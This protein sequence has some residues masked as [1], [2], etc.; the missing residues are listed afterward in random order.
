MYYTPHVDRSNK[1]LIGL[2]AVEDTFGWTALAIG[3]NGGMKGASQIVVR[4]ME[5][6]SSG[7]YDDTWVVED[8]NSQDY[9][10]PSLDES[11]DLELIFAEQTANGETAWGVLLPINSCDEFDYSVHNISM[12]MHWAVGEDHSFSFHG[13]RRGQFQANL[14]LP[15]P[16]TKDQGLSDSY[17]M[18]LLM[19]IVSVVSGE[20]EIP[21]DPYICSYFELERLPLEGSKGSQRFVSAN[22]KSHSVRVETVCSQQSKQ[23]VHH[24]I[25]YACDADLT[26]KSDDDIFHRKLNPSCQ[27]MPPHCAE[28]KAVWSLGVGEDL[29]MP[30][31]VGLPFGEGKRWLVMQVH[32]YNPGLDVGIYDSSGMRLHIAPKPRSYDAGQISLLGGFDSA[33]HPNGIPAGE[34]DFEL[35]TFVVPSVCT[36][37]MWKDPINIMWVVHHMHQYGTKMEIE[38][39]REGRS[40]GVL[41]DEK[42]FD[43]TH[44]SFT[45]SLVSQLLPGDAIFLRCRY[46]TSG[47][48][49]NVH[50]GDG[51][52][53]E[54]CIAGINYWP[55]QRV[56]TQSVAQVDPTS[57]IKQCQNAGSGVFSK[58][59]LC[60][61]SFFE[62]AHDFLTL[63]WDY[64]EPFDAL[65]FCNSGIFEDDVLPRNLPISLCPDC[66]VNK[67][68]TA[69]EVI[70]HA[71][72]KVCVD[73][74]SMAN[75]SVYPDLS[76]SEGLSHGITRCFSGD[77]QSDVRFFS[78]PELEA[79]VP[80]CEPFP[81]A[82]ASGD[83]VART[84]DASVWKVASLSMVGII[85]TAVVLFAF[86]RTTFYS[87]SETHCLGK[88]SHMWTR[89]IRSFEVNLVAF[90]RQIARHAALYPRTYVVAIS[91]LSLLLLFLGFATNF[92]VEADTLSWWTPAGT[93]SEEHLNYVTGT[94]QGLP[95]AF[96]IMVHKQGDNAV[97]KE[98]VA[99][100]FEALDAIRATQGFDAVCGKSDH[101][102]S[103]SG[104]GTCKI[105]G[106]TAFWNHS[107]SLFEAAV[108]SDEDI[109]L[110]LSEETFPDGRPMDVRGLVGSPQWNGTGTKL[111]G[112]QSYFAVVE[113][114]EK[115]EAKAYDFEEDALDSVLHLRNQWKQQIGNA[116]R[117]EVEATRSFDDEANRSIQ[118][119]LPLIQIVGVVMSVF[120]CLVYSKCD[121]VKSQSLLGF[122]AVVSVV[123]ST[124]SGFGLLFI[125][126][127]P[128]TT[129]TS[130]LP[131]IVLGIGLDDAFII[132][133]AYNR[134][135]QKKDPVERIDETISEAGLSIAITTVT[136]VLAFGLDT[137]TSIP[138]VDWLCCYAIPMLLI[139]FFYQITF[140]VA[141]IVIDDKRIKANRRDCCVCFPVSATQLGTH[142]D[143]DHDE[144]ATVPLPE[145]IMSSYADKLLQPWVK[146][147]ILVGFAVL[148][149]GL[150]YSASLMTQDFK[151]TDMLPSDSYVADNIIAYQNYNSRSVMMP[152]MYFRGVDQSNEDVQRQMEA[153]VNDMVVGINAVEQPTSG[154]F[155]LSHFKQ[156][157]AVQ[158]GT[159]FEALNFKEKLNKFLQEPVFSEL[160]SNDIV[161]DGDGNIISSCMLFFISDLDINNVEEQVKTLKA[162]RAVSAAQPINY[163]K[164][165]WSFFAYHRNFNYW[166]FN[167]VAVEELLFTSVIGV[168]SVTD[169]ALIL[170]PH[171]SG[172]LFVFPL[173]SVLYVDLLGFLQLVG[174]SVNAV[175]YIAV[176]MSIGL[177]VDYIL[178][179]LV[180][181]YECPGTRDQKV[182]ESLCCMGS[183]VL[184]GALTTFLGMVPLAFTTSGVGK[185]LFYAFSGLVVFGALHGLVLLPVLLSLLGPLD[186][187]PSQLSL[188]KEKKVEGEEESE[189]LE[190]EEMVTEH[191][192]GVTEETKPP[193]ASVDANASLSE[194]DQMSNEI[195]V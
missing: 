89:T 47:L 147:V 93:R 154:Y 150:A 180:K 174:V 184:L 138:A 59:S 44:Q 190:K 95:R 56:E 65:H 176:V 53:D 91:A 121:P 78:P 158:F 75:V 136:S 155:W 127:V 186:P 30:S 67:N 131:F 60:A 110:T 80:S 128:Y 177:M 97:S 140:F 191:V 171:W 16:E 77:I 143:E 38:I 11:Q 105:H 117:L 58:M 116:F 188:S 179:V 123:L 130:L 43:F 46:D 10:M 193:V 175:S 141:L 29:V 85:A 62:H 27:T 14:F 18:D 192:V 126:G 165:D 146:A 72:E 5:D 189:D 32:Y 84:A 17:T 185:I 41:V 13:R 61:Q 8:R 111:S 98:G 112:G 22:D 83:G 102:D 164:D 92:A 135:D 40:L 144:A 152:Y 49:Q 166:E 82:A 170:I 19:S 15:P 76:A 103:E 64:R 69:E 106:V 183:S 21:T 153:Y 63:R 39:R 161:L 50:F 87:G 25:L 68:C 169:A 100:V 37:S 4:K 104:S 48:S 71:Q 54:M 1:I 57:F 31:D 124:S 134:T 133:A 120:V 7:V 109:I 3:G 118:E 42:H 160:Y 167:S 55:G 145:R 35:P 168:L 182:K 52:N 96:S 163:D 178:H 2:H 34:T 159:S 12:F 122:G 132:T 107:T 9:T 142:L 194:T 115:Q 172:A 148:F 101:V 20:G 139:T 86:Y 119:D 74:C 90:L 129:M 79:Q 195:S 137:L 45:P 99:H 149:G 73:F 88:F 24:I 162:Q 151:L 70:L 94:F 157:S 81:S 181:Y 66:Y 28:V 33:Q 125:I 187:S 51:T 113:L 173:L 108:S 26:D 6:K 36:Y 23:Y 114:P 156:Y